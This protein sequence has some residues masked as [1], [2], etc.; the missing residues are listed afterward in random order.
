[1]RTAE[2]QSELKQ[3]SSLNSVLDASLLAANVSLEVL[4]ATKREIEAQLERKTLEAERIAVRAGKSACWAEAEGMRAE[5]AVSRRFLA[6]TAAAETIAAITSELKTC[7]DEVERRRIESEE[8]AEQMK[9]FQEELVKRARLEKEVAVQHEQIAVLRQKAA[10]HEAVIEEL[11]VE[12][13][14]L[15]TVR[16]HVL[17]L[18]DKQQELKAKL[19]KTTASLEAA[20]AEHK[21]IERKLREKN[22]Q[23]RSLSTAL[24][25]TVLLVHDWC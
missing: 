3:V 20:R 16:E 18:E 21:A 15:D 4:A 10:A 25:G 23:N 17:R 9:S 12:V 6:D 7:Q 2:L 5:E 13:A 24:S 22:G 19:L 11:R 14:L 8:H 1:Q